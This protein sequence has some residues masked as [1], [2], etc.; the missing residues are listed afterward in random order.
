MDYI[1]RL[2]PQ[3]REKTMPNLK[4]MDIQD[5]LFLGDINDLSEEPPEITTD[6]DT[7]QSSKEDQPK[8]FTLTLEDYSPEMKHQ[9]KDTIINEVRATNPQNYSKIATTQSSK[10]NYLQ[11]FGSTLRIINETIPQNTK[12]TPLSSFPDFLIIKWEKTKK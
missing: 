11:D 6:I 5:T 4:R 2:E 7:A 10:D 8:D 3:T 1:P 9:N 12:G